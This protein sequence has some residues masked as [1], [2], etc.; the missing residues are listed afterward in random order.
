MSGTP[1]EQ[2]ELEAAYVLHARPYR[3]ASQLLE[4]FARRYGRLG[5]VARGARG[6]RPRWRGALQPFRPLRLSWRGRGSL[7]SLRAAEAAAAPLPLT[8]ASLM[9]AWYLNELIL[10]LTTRGDPHP[11]LFAHY[12]AALAGLAEQGAAEL[13]LRR[14]ELALLTEL[15]YGLTVG[16]VAHSGAP[17]DPEADY[18]YLADAGPIP[19]ADSADAVRYRGAELLAIAAGRLEEPRLLRKA[20]SLLGS[21]IR[22]H[23]GGRELR[24]R[25][26]FEAMRRMQP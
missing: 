22:H 4:V 5:L 10:A 20:R 1:V 24:T 18:V 8:G 12:G 6:P 2:V 17:L 11:D 14:F 16:H 9:S 3:E 26:V 23:L 19:A 25:R 21:L 13:V 15:G 7:Y